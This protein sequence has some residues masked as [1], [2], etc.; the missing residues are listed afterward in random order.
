MTAMTSALD[1]MET[2]Q[3]WANNYY[4][5]IAERLYDVAVGR[6]LRHLNPPFG[7]TVLDAGCGTGVHSVRVARAG[8]Q[9]CAV[10]ISRPVLRDARR[11]A[12][13]AGVADCVTFQHADL[14]SLPY[15]DE[16]FDAVFSWGVIIHIPDV[17]AALA[18]LVRV[19]KPGGRIAL[20]ITNRKAWEGAVEGVARLALNKPAIGRQKQHFGVGSW[21]RMHGGRLWNWRMDIPSVIAEM[22]RL[23]CMPVHHSAVEFT[24]LQRRLPG[25]L[26]SAVLRLNNAYL[27][28]GLPAGPASTNLLVFEKPPLPLGAASRPR[29]AYHFPASAL[30]MPRTPLPV[31][32]PLRPR[33]PNAARA[34]RPPDRS[35]YALRH[36]GAKYSGEPRTERTRAVSGIRPVH[37]GNPL[38]ARVRSVRGSSE[39]LLQLLRDTEIRVRSPRHGG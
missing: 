18:E 21:C 9:T 26:R 31:G 23:D 36:Y 29:I 3:T 7:G 2:F 28:M 13:E 34:A 39:Y 14:T 12:E 16:R 4:H 24:E 19:L 10:D 11:R 27:T 25:V 17:S 35:R 37:A 20:Q 30:A 5:P 6:M 1:K 22:Q 32:R 8:F 33:I 38:T 15:E